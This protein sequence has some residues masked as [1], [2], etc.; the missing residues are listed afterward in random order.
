MSKYVPVFGYK[1]KNYNL[2]RVFIHG[3]S[4]TLTFKTAISGNKIR[5]L[6]TNKFS[7]RNLRVLRMY[8]IIEGVKY[9]VTLK[10][11]RWFKLKP[12]QEVYSDVI[13]LYQDNYD[14]ITIETKFGFFAKGYSAGDFNST[15][16]ALVKH[17]GIF[18]RKV[19][20][21]LR[22]KAISKPHLQISLL[23]KQVEIIDQKAKSVAWLGDSL[24]NHAY[25]TQALQNRIIEKKYPVSIINAGQSGNRLLKDGRLLLKD[26]F[27]DS[28]LSRIENDIFKF[29]K[30]AVVVVAVGINDLIHPATLVSAEELPETYEMIDGYLELLKIIKSHKSKAVITTITPFNGYK[31]NVLPQ[32]EERRKEINAWIR[33]QKD[34]DW[35]FDLD[36]IVKDDQDS[37]WL[38]PVF[39]G[40]DN[41]HFLQEGGQIIADKFDLE[42]LIK[43]LELD[44]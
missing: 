2:T 22:T 36:A 17:Y 31:D 27:G 10:N 25:Y 7:P 5:I 34:Y 38:A 14:F 26:I 37:T 9:N 12:N 33:S 16:Q 24:T 41:L 19:N 15:K 1:T 20:L 43:L 32:A 13:N 40:D 18:N 30:P 44:N 39:R 4:Q 6:F 42:S 8:L 35:V 23:I 11:K 3:T 28:A 21:G 29:N